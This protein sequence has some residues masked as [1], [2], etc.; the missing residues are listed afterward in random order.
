MG[1]RSSQQL[2]IG[3]MVVAII[4]GVWF[5]ASLLATLE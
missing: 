2:K 5:I 3:C 4:F 1:R